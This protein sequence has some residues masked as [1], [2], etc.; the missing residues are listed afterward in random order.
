MYKYTITIYPKL[1]R[2]LK[3]IIPHPNVEK[4]TTVILITDSVKRNSCI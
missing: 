3:I 4:Y 1:I 2:L